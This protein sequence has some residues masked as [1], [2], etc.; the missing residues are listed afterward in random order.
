MGI[1]SRL[2][3]L[4]RAG[5]TMIAERLNGEA[6]SL[7]ALIPGRAG[8]LWQMQL[9][10]KSEPEAG[11]ERLHLRAHF[12]LSLRK[13]LPAPKDN[14]GFQTATGLPARVGQWIER[15]MD[16][17]LMQTLAA[18]L[19]DRDLNTWVEVQ[20]ST[21]P[22]DAGAK[23]LLPTQL[24]RLGIEPKNDQAVQAWA[25][26]LRGAKPGFAQMTLLQ[27]DQRHLPAN[28]KNAFADKPF[29]LSAAVVNVIE[30]SH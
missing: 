5:E 21:A 30:E 14:P 9:E 19:L 15:R 7:S 2:Q 12:K 10:M 29:Q 8:P 3:S 27:L 16:S 1:V 18:P 6:L 11:G 26:E 28:L 13:A 4:R 24:A 23:A 17:R 20:S 22:L 25:G